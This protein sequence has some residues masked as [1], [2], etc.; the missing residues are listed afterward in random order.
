VTDVPGEHAH[1]IPIGGPGAAQG[2]GLQGGAGASGAI[3]LALVVILASAAAALSAIDAPVRMTLEGAAGARPGMTVAEVSTAWGMRLRPSYEVRPDCG[4][5]LLETRGL[6]GYAIFMPRGRF[7][8]LFLR[9]GAISGR[10]VKIGSSLADLR[11][12]YPRLTSR[13]DRY[14]HG[15]RQYFLRRAR[16]PHWELRFDVG[17]GK[18]VTQIVFGDRASVRLDEGCA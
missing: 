13:P 10:G 18:R 1:G 7:G 15:G 3:V 14:V 9:K 6:R 2:A 11:R 4:Q 16:T 8:A 12:R 17:P 5:A